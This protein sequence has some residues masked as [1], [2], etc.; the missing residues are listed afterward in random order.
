MFLL[1]LLACGAS[2][3]TP[4]YVGEVDVF[5]IVRGWDGSG[6][7]AIEACGA[8]TLVEADG[9]FAAHMASSCA[10]RVVWER[11]D[12]RARGPWIAL[13]ATSPIVKIAL[14]MP[15]PELLKPLSPEALREKEGY[16]RSAQGQL[17]GD[18]ESAS[19][20]ETSRDY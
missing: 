3:P 4:P 2:E 15:D 18:D 13:N 8:G 11:D 5:G 1:L 6:D 14:D 20:P 17:D 12:S 19:S 16:I 7:V 9:G 10:V